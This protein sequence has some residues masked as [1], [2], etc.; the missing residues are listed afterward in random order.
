MLI[1]LFLFYATSE[2]KFANLKTDKNIGHIV[3]SFYNNCSDYIDEK[4][5]ITFI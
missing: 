5:V 1:T 3:R 4:L 2:F